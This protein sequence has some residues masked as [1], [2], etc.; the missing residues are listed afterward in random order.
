MIHG[1]LW[2]GSPYDKWWDPPVDIDIKDEEGAQKT[3]GALGF[4]PQVILWVLRLSIMRFDETL[5][6]VSECIFVI[7]IS[8]VLNLKRNSLSVICY[9]QMEENFPSCSYFMFSNLFYDL[10]GA[11]NQARFSTTAVHLIPMGKTAPDHCSLQS[12]ECWG[13]QLLV[14]CYANGRKWTSKRQDQRRHPWMQNYAGVCH[15]EVFT[16]I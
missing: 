15:S 16:V 3:K 10:V 13:I 9:I 8:V 7:I 4:S 5:Q 12:S 2:L 14:G 1:P 11:E 6:Q